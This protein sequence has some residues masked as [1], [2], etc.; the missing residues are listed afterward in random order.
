LLIHELMHVWQYERIGAMYIPLALRAQHTTVGYNYGG[1]S[2][3]K[4]NGH[5]GLWDFN[6][7][8]QA[9]LVADYY[10]IQAGYNPQWGIG[11]KKDVAVYEPFIRELQKS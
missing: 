4:H 7:E 2:Y 5:K 8:Q 3:L 9:D 1:V 6:L 10:L 11:Q